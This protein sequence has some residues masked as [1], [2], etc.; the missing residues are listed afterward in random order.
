[1][2]VHPGVKAMTARGGIAANLLRF[3]YFG[4]PAHAS[5]SPDKG[6]NALDACIQTFNSI[7]ARCANM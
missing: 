4:K 3:E 5:S 6:I 2:M 7:N 1:M